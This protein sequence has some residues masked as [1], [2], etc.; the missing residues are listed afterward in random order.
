MQIILYGIV[1]GIT[2]L[3]NIIAY[4]A[5]TRLLYIPVVA[6]TVIAWTVAVIF[7]YWANR[8]FV[9]H[10]TVNT[11]SGILKEASEFLF[12]RITTGV[13]DVIIMYLFVDVFGFYDVIVKTVSNI[14][15]I[16]LNYIASKIIIFKGEKSS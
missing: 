7:A 13:L 1:G 2:T 8:K 6:S 15:V 4:W 16:I 5:C 14:I 12:F 3:I 9:F 11:L 10:S